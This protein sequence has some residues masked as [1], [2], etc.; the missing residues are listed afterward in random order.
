MIEKVCYETNNLKSYCKDLY[1]KKYKIKYSIN[2]ECKKLKLDKTNQCYLL[3]YIKHN[4]KQ[5]IQINEIPKFAILAD[6]IIKSL[7]V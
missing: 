7:P 3:L 6:V 1:I 4:K 5:K 2:I